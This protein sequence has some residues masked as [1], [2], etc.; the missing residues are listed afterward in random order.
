MKLDATYA[1]HARVRAR[2]C[3]LREHPRAAS[4]NKCTGRASR[5]ASGAAEGET[6]SPRR[7]ADLET[8]A[9]IGKRVKSGFKRVENMDTY[10]G[11]ATSAPG[12]SAESNA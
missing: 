5:T 10:V 9:E 11:A 8:D 6:A 2:V 12:Q 3:V 1:M 4:I 7:G